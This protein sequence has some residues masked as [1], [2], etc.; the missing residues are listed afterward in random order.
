MDYVILG[1]SYVGCPESR[2]EA[3]KNAGHKSEKK[4]RLSR[5]KN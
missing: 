2:F 1:L 4:V 3:K 5:M